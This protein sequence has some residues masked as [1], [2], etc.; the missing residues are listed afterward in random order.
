MATTKAKVLPTVTRR[1]ENAA[2]AHAVIMGREPTFSPTKT[3]TEVTATGA[4][5]R[6]PN[7]RPER[8]GTDSFGERVYLHLTPMVID[9]FLE[10][11]CR[12]NNITRVCTEL[13]INR[14]VIYAM[15]AQDP[16]FR[17]RLSD[18]QSL[19][20]DAWE[21]AAATRAFDG[22]D[23]KVFHQGIQIDTVKDYSDSIAIAM[24]KGAKPERYAAQTRNETIVG[25]SLGI[26]LS[27]LSDNELNE[28]ING[29]LALLGAITKAEANAASR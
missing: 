5:A 27:E 22:V 25:G 9:L 13:N 11:V 16:V 14:L 12:T 28:K 20:I 2:N 26:N 17:Q 23:R 4:I 19:G 15:K 24:L 21:D 3:T 7:G 29:K 6:G 10:G 18:A 1:Q 8:I